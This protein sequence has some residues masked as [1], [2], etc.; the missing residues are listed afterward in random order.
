MLELD[1]Q[2]LSEELMEAV[3]LAAVVE[4]HHEEIRAGELVK[5]FRASFLLEH[6]VAEGA[7]H[8]SQDR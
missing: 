7:A 8:P 4:R 2:E 6:R 1:A 3:P 5:P